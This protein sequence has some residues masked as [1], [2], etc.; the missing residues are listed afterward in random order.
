MNRIEKENV[1]HTH[2]HTHTHT[3]SDKVASQPQRKNRIKQS[4][5]KYMEHI[6]TA[7]TQKGK[8]HML[9]LSL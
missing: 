2:T 9:S 3:H 1:I 6:V 5:E 8:F 7:Q 4:V